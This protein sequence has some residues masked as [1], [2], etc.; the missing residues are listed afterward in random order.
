MVVMA[1]LFAGKC[2]RCGRPIQPGTQMEWTK[3]GGALHLTPEE[4][5]AA[6]AI[7][8]LRGP[9][10]ELPEERTRVEQLLLSHEW[11]RATSAKYEKLPHAY[12]LRRTWDNDEDFL[13]CVEYIRR[14]GYQERFIGRVWTYL[15]VREF[16]YWTMG[17]PVPET[18]LINRAVRRTASA[19]SKVA[20]GP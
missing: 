12:T 13:W 17:A 1:A 16:Q 3:A 9:Q 8:E 19:N 10:S 20:S 2:R 6:P 14:V 5:A 11:K 18:T 7:L 15:D 4:C